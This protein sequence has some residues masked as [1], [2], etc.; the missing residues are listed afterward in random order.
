[1]RLDRIVLHTQISCFYE[2]KDMVEKRNKKK[3][4]A[5]SWEKKEKNT[6]EHVGRDSMY[7]LCIYRFGLIFLG[8]AG[9]EN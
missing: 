7:V 1:M 6:L 5:Y 2:V 4:I 9:Q 3:R 8:Q